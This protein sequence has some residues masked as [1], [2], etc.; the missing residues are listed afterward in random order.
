MVH[1][2]FS[3][4]GG[5]SWQETRSSVKTSFTTSRLVDRHSEDLEPLRPLAGRP[6]VRGGLGKS[7][8]YRK[9]RYSPPSSTPALKVWTLVAR[10]RDRLPIV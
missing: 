10:G 9:H 3:G 2:L 7:P 4:P 1:D 5:A 8:Y 6:E